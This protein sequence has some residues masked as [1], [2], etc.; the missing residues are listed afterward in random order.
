MRPGPFH[1][2][3]A[4]AS[5]ILARPVQIVSKAHGFVKGLEAMTHVRSPLIVD[6]ARLAA[7]RRVRLGDGAL[8]QAFNRLTG[9]IATALEAPVALVVLV[10]AERQT[11]PGRF[12]RDEPWATLAYL[13]LTHSF[14]QHIVASGEPLIV[15]DA[16]THPLV[17][18]NPAVAEYSVVAYLG[19]PLITADGQRLGTV[20]AI[21]S[22]PRAWTEDNLRVLQTVAS[23]VL[24]ELALHEALAELDAVEQQA[25]RRLVAADAT[26]H[27]LRA[28][29]ER[30]R[31]L[32]ATAQ[33]Q[34]RE[35]ALLDRVRTALARELD[36]DSV[37]RTVVEGFAE[38]FGYTQV[39]LYLRQGDALVLQHQVGYDQVFHRIPLSEG[40]AGRVV[41][42]GQPALLEDVR[43]D[44]A[45]L[46]AIAGIVSEVCV[47][48][49]DDGKVVGILNLESTQGV[50]LGAADLRL[51][52]ALSQ[53]VTIAFGR[54]R[55]YSKVSESERRLAALLRNLPGMAYRARATPAWADIFL[56]DGCLELTGYSPAELLAGPALRYDTLIHPDE[57]EGRLAAIDAAVREQQP[58]QAVYRLIT[59]SGREKWVWEQ[60][61]G[62]FSPSDELEAYEGFVTDI[63]ERKRAEDAL[64]ESQRRFA[65]IFRASP[66]TIAIS[67]LATGRFVDV[68]ER[69]L[70]LVEYTRDEL[71]G[72]PA[73]AL[74]LWAGLADRTRVVVQLLEQGAI[75][76][77]EIPV[78]TRSGRIIET[79]SSFELIELD[80]VPC[81]L[82]LSQ[83][84]TERRRAEATL[85]MH[86]VILRNMAE[87]VCLVRASDAAI[88]YANPKFEQLFDYAPGELLGQLARV[89]SEGDLVRPSG[90]VAEALAALT[91]AEESVMEVP[92]LRPDGRPFWCQARRATFVHPRHGSMWVG[93]YE[94]ITPR[95]EAEAARDHLISHLTEALANIKTL[96]GLVPI[97]AGCKKIR[98]DSG[99]WNQL[100]TYIQAHSE[101]QFSH[102]LCPDCVQRLYP[103]ID[104]L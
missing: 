96:R 12:A 33:R 99:F 16:H 63:T 91:R 58:F 52:L 25:T 78:R 1:A 7:L 88:L 41:R 92:L 82:A 69:F 2:L 30:A 87:G 94:D 95:K 79:L 20:C 34:A 84:V 62:L 59:A 38:T 53:Q 45:F 46:G 6:P 80:G 43:D 51:M 104:D 74:G 27:A 36:L 40:V 103:D 29:E 68:N 11:F 13:P 81:I 4:H 86:S 32:F 57:R 48:L 98:D 102:G 21:D 26:E 23:C 9:L 93:V 37:I 77:I 15:D 39:S 54:A 61:H 24:S 3:A 101:A 65:T 14:C 42:T 56:S 35:L 5:A 71:I 90:L 67:E 22:R 97:C 19:A 70:E 8:E 100:E 18:E 76:G 10:E 28:S 55:L 47:P 60:G 64:R 31:E 89:V 50:R 66:V 83:D 72:K 44:P 75:T 85:Q 49:H 17:R 73:Q